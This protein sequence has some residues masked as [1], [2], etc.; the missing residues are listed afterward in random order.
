LEGLVFASGA[1]GDML[2]PIRNPNDLGAAA[3]NKF[4][5]PR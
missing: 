5:T 2:A 4:A 1:D 3:N